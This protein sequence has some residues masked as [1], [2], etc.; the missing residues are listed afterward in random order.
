MRSCAIRVIAVV[1][2]LPFIVILLAIFYVIMRKRRKI[3]AEAAEMDKALEEE[4]TY[5]PR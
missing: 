3:G 2:V 4:Q 5:L 1:A